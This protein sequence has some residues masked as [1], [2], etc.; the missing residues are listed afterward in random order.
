MMSH[1]TRLSHQELACG[2]SL[3]ELSVYNGVALWWFN[4]M[5]VFEAIRQVIADQDR[6]AGG[7]ARHDRKR[8][9]CQMRS[10]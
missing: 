10:R 8:L 6:T 2:K 1:W 9:P 4:Q 3:L 7:T 5:E